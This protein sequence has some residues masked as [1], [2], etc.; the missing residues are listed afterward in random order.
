MTISNRGITHYIQ[1]VGEFIRTQ[2]WEREARQFNKLRKIQ[3]FREYKIWK[4]FVLW[5]K[6]QRKNAMKKC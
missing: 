6:T 5:K 1:G 4:N 2:D 3:F